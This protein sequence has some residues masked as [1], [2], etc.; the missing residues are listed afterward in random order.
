MDALVNPLFAEE[1]ILKEINNVNSEI[2]MRYTFNKSLGV[3]KA[4][5]T[6]GNKKN[7][8]FFDGFDNIDSSKVDVTQLKKDLTKFHK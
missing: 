6:F 4:L 8:M 2:S 5:K 1:T 3:Y 7:K